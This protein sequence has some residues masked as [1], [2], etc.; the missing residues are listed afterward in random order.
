MCVHHVEGERA[1]PLLDEGSGAFGDA[2]GE[3]RVVH[4]LEPA[5]SG[6]LIDDEGEMPASQPGMPEALG[7]ERRP[8]QPLHEE[9]LQLFAAGAQVIGINGTE[10]GVVLDG[11]IEELNGTLDRLPAAGE[12]EE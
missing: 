9:E 4:E 11:G 3:E 6:F 12:F 2:G 1:Q 7:V 5:L 10:H 8:A